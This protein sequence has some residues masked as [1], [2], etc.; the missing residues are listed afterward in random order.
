MFEFKLSA[1]GYLHISHAFRKGKENYK[2]L[3]LLPLLVEK[4]ALRVFKMRFR[5]RISFRA[6][7]N[8]NYERMIH[9][10]KFLP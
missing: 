6:V 10:I 8:I 4:A 5:P 7:S 3:S 9:L 2:L 1:A